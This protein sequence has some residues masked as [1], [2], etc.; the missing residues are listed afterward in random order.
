MLC[1]IF[2]YGKMATRFCIVHIDDMNFVGKND[3]MTM[4]LWVW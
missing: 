4:R 3:E 2:Y 1:L